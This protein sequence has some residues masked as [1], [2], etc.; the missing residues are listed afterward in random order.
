MAALFAGRVL[1]A[2]NGARDELDTERE[3]ARCLDNK[4]LLLY[5]AA[6]ACPRCRAFSPLLR[7]FYVRLTDEFYVERASQLVL[8]YVSRDD[9]EEKQSRFLKS[10]PKRWLSLPF[11]DDF[12]RELA[13]RFAVAAVPA[14]VVLA[15]DGRLIAA[16]AV[17]EIRRAGPACFK[18]WQE[19]AA[20]VDRN[21]LAAEDFDEVARR[22]LTDPV[23]RLKYKLGKKTRDEEEEEGEGGRGG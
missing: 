7:D 2:N 11:E 10:M 22:S 16:N 17:E 23:R 19:A 9:T 8:V 14:V 5:F 20:L 18:N 15:P 1:V 13:E 3:L 21:F 12:K 4:V 6:A